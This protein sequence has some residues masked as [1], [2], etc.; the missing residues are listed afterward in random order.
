MEEVWSTVHITELA[1]CR[2]KTIE[3]ESVA[4]VRRKIFKVNTTKLFVARFFIS[5]V[6]K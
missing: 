4:P 1:H 6:S 5:K 3:T 2:L